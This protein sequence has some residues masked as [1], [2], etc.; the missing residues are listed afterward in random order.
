MAR[1][2]SREKSVSEINV[3]PLIDVM[4]V[5]LIIFMVVSAPLLNQASRSTCRKASPKPR[6]SRA[7]A[8]GAD[9]RS[10]GHLYLNRADDPKLA[11]STEDLL[12]RAR[13]VLQREAKTVVLVKGDKGVEY[14]KVVAAMHLLTQAGAAKVGLS[15][16]LPDGA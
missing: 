5:L 13:A 14:G 1:R 3:V 4:L 8:D 7:G 10:R 11:L 9:R 6:R 12:I 15:M 16:D 2:S